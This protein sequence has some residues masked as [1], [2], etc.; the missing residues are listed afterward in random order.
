MTGTMSEHTSFD[1]NRSC[2]MA[3]VGVRGTTALRPNAKSLHAHSYTQPLEHDVRM[4]YSYKAVILGN[5]R[6]RYRNPVTRWFESFQL[7]YR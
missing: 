6:L 2:S 1:F 4:N 3:H 7:P 5:H